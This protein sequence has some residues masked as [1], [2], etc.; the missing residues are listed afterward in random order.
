MKKEIEE[1]TN[2]DKLANR[3]L[4]AV[5][6]SMFLIAVVIGL[7]AYSVM[8]EGIDIILW[9]VLMIMG[10]TFAVLSPMQ[11]GGTTN[12]GPSNSDYNLVLGALMLVIGLA[13]YTWFHTDLGW[14]AP[15]ALILLTVA[16]VGIVI[17]IKNRK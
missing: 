14:L 13:G 6:G 11:R 2:K 1:M 3:T 15:V 9:V 12:F 5:I 4:S 10:L 17:T 8:D 7:V 16:A